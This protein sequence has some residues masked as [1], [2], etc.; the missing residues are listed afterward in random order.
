[1]NWL[2]KFVQPRDGRNN[3][4]APAAQ[5]S[6][7]AEICET[8]ETEEIFEKDNE[9]ETVAADVD[10]ESSQLS[11]KTLA[12]HFH[13]LLKNKSKIQSTAK[14]AVIEEK[15]FSLMKR[16]NERLEKRDQQKSEKRTQ[17]DGEELFAQ[18]LALDLKQ[19]PQY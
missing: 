8:N 13:P 18:A 9:D 12:K 3:L 14:E 1:M 5:Q 15:E 2:D 4:P 16:L 10:D 7:H 19:L 6:E 11:D 17:P